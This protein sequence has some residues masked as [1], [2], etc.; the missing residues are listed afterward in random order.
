MTPKTPDPDYQM[1]FTELFLAA[2]DV[3][4]R[5]ERQERTIA[6]AESCTGGLLAALFTGVEGLSNQFERGFVCYTPEAKIQMLGVPSDLIETH[7]VVSEEVAK[8][9]AAGALERAGVDLAVGITGFTGPAGP[10]DEQGLVWIAVS[11]RAR[12]IARD[13]HFGEM[14]RGPARAGAAARALEM[15][16]GELDS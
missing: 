14:R 3:L 12:T 5:A 1:R 15:L 4:A 9:M 16:R 8:A 6:V 10:G 7:G 11:S 2:E 13:C